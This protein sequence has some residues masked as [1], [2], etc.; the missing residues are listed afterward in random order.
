[1]AATASRQLRKA[2]DF[3]AAVQFMVGAEFHP[4]A[5]RTTLRL[6]N[7]FAVRMEKSKDGH[8]P[9]S[10]DAT[11][12]M[13]GLSR[14]A[15]F[16]H[17]RILR[18]LGLIAYVEHGTRTNSQRTRHGAAWTPAHGYRG[19]AT[20]FAAVA[21]PVWDDAMGRRIAGTGYRARPI[22]VTQ[23]GRIRAID[24]A[25]RSAGR[26]NCRRSS[27]TPSLVVPQD[28]GHQQVGGGEKY[29]SRT[30]ATGRKTTS[31][32][33]QQILPRTSPAECARQIAFAEQL[34]REVW[35]LHRCCARRLAYV[36]RPLFT[37]GWTWQSLAAELRAWGVPGYLRDPAAY[38]HSELDQF[39]RLGRLGHAQLP[40][41]EVLVDEQGT[42]HREMVHARQRAN[43]LAWRSYTERLR[44]ELRRQVAQ[45]RTAGNGGP[46][47]EYLSWLREPEAVHL[48]ALPLQDA[49]G[50]GGSPQEIYAA[51][52][53]NRPMPVRH[54]APEADQG[55]LDQMRD[56]IEAKRACAVLRA[57]LDDWEAEQA[58]Y[59]A[60][61]FR[62]GR[63]LDERESLDR[64]GSPC[65]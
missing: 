44:P 18:E 8:F 4:K 7:A 29:T 28:H 39:R 38:V 19:T 11:G 14:R 45:A 33:T 50:P 30:R 51:R 23:Q 60:G 65:S 52:A 49:H 63:R 2:D 3:R 16:H 17:A 24:E 64:P 1:M 36:L 22:G 54:A 15:V 47:A 26:D 59:G 10:A 37:S 58:Q 56:E 46:R 21:P 41:R 57:E 32:P 12:R 43:K 42:R 27:C 40:E 53:T 34:Q 61:L 6:A 55:W 5:G 62:R 48:H 35:W 20:L 9:F 13:L 25:R 31:R